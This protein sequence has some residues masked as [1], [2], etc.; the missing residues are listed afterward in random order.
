MCVK[1]ASDTGTFFVAR[2]PYTI[3]SSNIDA[4]DQSQQRHPQARPSNGQ[5]RSSMSANGLANPDDRDSL[6]LTPALPGKKLMDASCKIQSD[7]R[8]PMAVQ[9]P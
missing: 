2:L 3:S 6:E 8:K 9:A 5:A 4:G 7:S 1:L